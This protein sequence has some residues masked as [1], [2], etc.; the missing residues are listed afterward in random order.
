MN[1]NP[2]KEREGNKMINPRRSQKETV[3]ERKLRFGEVI[4]QYLE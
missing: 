4:L 1:I 3:Y 2:Y